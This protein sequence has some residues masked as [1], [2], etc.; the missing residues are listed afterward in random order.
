MTVEARSISEIETT[1]KNDVSTRLGQT[2]PF[3]PKAF[4]NVLAKVF[5]AVF[6]VLH[7]YVAFG[8]L[9]IFVRHSSAKATEFNGKM[10]V[11]LYEWGQLF[12]E[13]LPLPGQRAEHTVN[14]PVITQVGSL[15]QGTV[16]LRKPTGVLY[17]SAAPVAL[18]S[19]T[20]VVTVRAYSDQVDRAGYGALGNLVAGDELELANAPAAVSNFATVTARTVDGADPEDIETSYR[21]RVVFAVARPKQGGAE[22]DYYSWVRKVPGILGAWPYRGTTPNRVTVYVLAT[23][24]SSG[25]AD[26]VPTGPQLTAVADAIQFDDEGLRKRRPV[27]ALVTVLPITRK[28]LA[29]RVIGLAVPDLSTT[30]AA[31]EAACDQYLRQ[32]RPW[33]GGLD[34]LPARHQASRA[35]LGGVVQSIVAANKGIFQGVRLFDGLTEL[36][37]Y[38]LQPGELCKLASITFV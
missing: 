5:A 26:G 25:S 13:G 1:I 16:F 36:D 33:I 18:S 14:L 6:V 10:V 32:R 17:E 3:F 12:G 22:S 24:E 21:E 28:G 7:K 23:A 8:I 2:I 11:P 38:T 4:T 31:I 35:G 37:V 15:P 9:Q 34:L 20:V 30:Q 19:S 27:G 29:V